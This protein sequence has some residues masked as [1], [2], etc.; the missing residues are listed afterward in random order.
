MKKHEKNGATKKTSTNNHAARAGMVATPNF[1]APNASALKTLSPAY[2]KKFI[3]WCTGEHKASDS[4]CSYTL[5]S[6]A[7]TVSAYTLTTYISSQSSGSGFSMSNLTSQAGLT[8][9]TLITQELA[10]G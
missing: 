9:A 2:E 4:V 6:V 5:K 3:D 7:S 8:V 10:T 1:L